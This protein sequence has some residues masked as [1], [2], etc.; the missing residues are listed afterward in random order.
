MK[1]KRLQRQTEREFDRRVERNSQEQFWKEWKEGN[2]R[3]DS[4]TKPWS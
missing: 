1:N 3:S 4:K 2:T